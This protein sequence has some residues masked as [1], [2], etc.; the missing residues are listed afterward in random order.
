MYQGKG[1]GRI[2]GVKKARYIRG[3]EGKVYQGKGRGRI[4]GVKKARYIR[5][6]EGE[7]I[8]E[9]EGDVYQG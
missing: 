2:S 9:R 1:R 3:K 6:K 5:G 8:R 4:S 7:C